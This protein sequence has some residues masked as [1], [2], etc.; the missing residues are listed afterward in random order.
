MTSVLRYQ[1]FC[2]TVCPWLSR[3][4]GQM[5]S[6]LGHRPQAVWWAVSRQP[7]Q[8]SQ[9]C[10]RAKANCQGMPTSSLGLRS[11]G[12][13]GL[14]GLWVFWFMPWV[15]PWPPMPFGL[16]LISVAPGSRQPRPPLV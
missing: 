15:S 13:G 4:F 7:L 14:L 11:L 3:Q 1:P 5:S 8:R 12:M 10:L 2:S 9:G 6:A 16:S